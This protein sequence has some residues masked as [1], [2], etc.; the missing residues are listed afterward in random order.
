MAR[1]KCVVRL[2]DDDEQVSVYVANLPG[3][4]TCGKDDEE[5]LSM[6]REAIECLLLSYR[7][8]VMPVPW[9]DPKP[10]RPGDRE[11]VIQVEAHG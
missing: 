10:I 6:A 2:Y 3:A 1:H 8:N 5:A 4:L 11:H 9:C 7:D